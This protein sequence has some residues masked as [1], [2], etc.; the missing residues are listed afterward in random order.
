[1]V[2]REQRRHHPLAA[3]VSSDGRPSLPQRSGNPSDPT[4]LTRSIS[5]IRMA[6]EKPIRDGKPCP[7]NRDEP[8]EK[9]EVTDQVLQLAGVKPY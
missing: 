1:V 9:I 6:K 5:N 4:V 8:F 2:L 7:K 3:L